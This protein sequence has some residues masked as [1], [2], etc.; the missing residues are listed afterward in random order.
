MQD[1][2]TLQSHPLHMYTDLLNSQFSQG[3]VLQ[4]VTRYQ[5]LPAVTNIRLIGL[6]SEQQIAAQTRAHWRFLP[7]QHLQISH[8]GSFKQH[9]H[10]WSAYCLYFSPQNVQL[11]L[12]LAVFTNK[13]GF[14]FL[15]I[16]KWKEC[17]TKAHQLQFSF[18]SKCELSTLEL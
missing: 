12:F 7:C 13:T 5:V 3:R 1:Y 2:V 15:R 9:S 4:S 10:T 6:R 8:V 11:F 14:L 16:L 18:S 17:P